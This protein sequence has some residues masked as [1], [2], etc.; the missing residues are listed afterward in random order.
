[1]T[2]EEEQLRADRK[3]LNDINQLQKVLETAYNNAKVSYNFGKDAQACFERTLKDYD[4]Y[5]VKAATIFSA[6]HAK[7]KGNGDVIQDKSGGTNSRD[8]QPPMPERSN[9]R[10]RN[11]R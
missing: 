3:R 8:S 10:E 4:G 6:T 9:S 1:M 7:V 5:V 11:W 2:K